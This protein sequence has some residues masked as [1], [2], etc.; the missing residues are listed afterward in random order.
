MGAQV[1]K[2]LMIPSLQFLAHLMRW[3]TILSLTSR[4]NPSSTEA[5][6]YC[7]VHD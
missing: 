2:S 3:G 1:E 7:I 6:F 4:C 5:D